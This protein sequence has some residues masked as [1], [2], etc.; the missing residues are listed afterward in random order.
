MSGEA[1][2][3]HK[4]SG[5]CKY[6]SKCR[7]RHEDRLSPEEQTC[8]SKECSFRH[9]KTCRYFYKKESQQN[10]MKIEEI[11]EKYE[12]E[13]NDIKDEMYK[14]TETIFLMQNKITELNQEIQS[15]KT[16]IISQIVG[17]VVSLLEN[18]KTS[19]KSCNTENTNTS[20]MQCD[21]C[22]FKSENE[23]QRISHMREEHEDCFCCYLCD[24]Y[25]ETKQSMKCH[26]E[27]IHNEK[28]NPTESECED[29][30]KI[31]CNEVNQ[32]QKK[33][34]KKEEK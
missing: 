16:I 5:F 12:N 21:V 25:L 28:Y 33:H 11:K 22:D 9:P 3:K 31:N 17:L 6:K 7:K 26:N 2:C 20:L 14:L 30:P 24:K 18:T 19:E 27:F 1:L 23:K 8:T 34:K 29:T 10:N 13:I 32:Q 15:S 4:H